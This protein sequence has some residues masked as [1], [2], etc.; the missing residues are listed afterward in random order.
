MSRAM[1]RYLLAIFTH[2]SQR[3]AKIGLATLLSELKLNQLQLAHPG[4]GQ[5]LDYRPDRH[6]QRF[7]TVGLA[8][9]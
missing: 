1:Q 4:R 9:V 6:L 7:S 3:E 5:T 2:A 8:C